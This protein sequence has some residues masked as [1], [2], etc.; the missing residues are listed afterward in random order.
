MDTFIFFSLFSLFHVFILFLSFTEYHLNFFETGKVKVIHHC[1]E[2]LRVSLEL[3]GG[4]IA[5]AAYIK[6]IKRVPDVRETPSYIPVT[7][8]SNT[9]SS[10]ASRPHHSCKDTENQLNLPHEK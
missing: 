5:T 4:N 8:H 2:V 3:C 6:G 10:L 1:T 7:K 9:R